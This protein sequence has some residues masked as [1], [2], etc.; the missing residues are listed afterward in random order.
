MQD[1]HIYMPKKKNIPVSDFPTD[2]KFYIATLMFIFNCSEHSSNIRLISEQSVSFGKSIAIWPA[3]V[4]EILMSRNSFLACMIC[5]GWP[6]AWVR[7]YS[8]WFGTHHTF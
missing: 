3:P 8:V 4:N 2:P 1:P 7:E 5:R 6:L